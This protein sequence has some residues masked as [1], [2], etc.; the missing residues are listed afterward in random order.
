[1]RRGRLAQ[2]KANL[3]VIINSFE[4]RIFSIVAVLMT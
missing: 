4:L 1:M 2:H 3:Y